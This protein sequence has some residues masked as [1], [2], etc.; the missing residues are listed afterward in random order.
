MSDLELYN[1][2]HRLTRELQEK[3]HS[4]LLDNNKLTKENQKLKAE[5]GKLKEQLAGYKVTNC[6]IEKQNEKMRECLG[7][8]SDKDQWDMDYDDDN[9]CYRYSLEEKW[10]PAQKCLEGL[11]K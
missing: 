3:C 2:I 7:F 9:Y 4:Q 8:Y 1:D 10:E 6:F 5:N 11:D